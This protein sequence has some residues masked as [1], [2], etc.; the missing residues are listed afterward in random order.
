[1]KLNIFLKGNSKQGALLWS[2]V[3]LP[4]AFPW[5]WLTDC[6]HGPSGKELRVFHIP[7]PTPTEPFPMSFTDGA[8]ITCSRYLTVQISITSG[9]PLP[10]GRWR[11]LGMSLFRSN[12]PFL[13][14][15][16]GPDLL[17]K[18][19]TL[20]G[21]WFFFFLTSGDSLKVHFA[22]KYEWGR[23]CTAVALSVCPTA[24]PCHM[25][26]ASVGNHC[27]K[28]WREAER[29]QGH[30]YWCEHGKGRLR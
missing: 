19:W 27:G 1:M 3:Y 4:S 16:C 12:Q 11:S 23:L 26:P 17:G 24:G 9:W 2:I 13:L 21:F 25:G 30:R 28:R 6:F 18:P 20:W 10:T 14:D 8:M 7:I 22:D 5:F 29:G 15:V